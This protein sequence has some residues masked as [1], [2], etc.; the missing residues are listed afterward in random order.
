MC[1]Y[2]KGFTLVE[3]VIVIAVIGI[4]AGLA[5]PHFL[6][7]Q[8]KT[9]SARAAADMRTLQSAIEQYM[10]AGY[11]L[12][13]LQKN[14]PFTNGEIMFA[15]LEEKGFIDSIPEAPQGVYYNAA[16]KTRGDYPAPAYGVELSSTGGTATDRYITVNFLNTKNATGGIYLNMYLNWFIYGK[17]DV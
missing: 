3:L 15:K 14:H 11:E 7:S 12:P 6:D 13:A 9:R 16:S 2:N 1:K 4:L 17:V 10:A 5:I 8:A